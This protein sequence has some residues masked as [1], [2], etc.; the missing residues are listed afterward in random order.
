MFQTILEEKMNMIFP[1]K[2][3]KTSS[4]D[5]EYSKRGQSEKYKK[6]KIKFDQKYKKAAQKYIDK[7]FTALKTENPGKAFSILKKW[8]PNLEIVGMEGPSICKTT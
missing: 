2:N 6:L 1:L 3:V 8:V 7:N 5:K 4:W